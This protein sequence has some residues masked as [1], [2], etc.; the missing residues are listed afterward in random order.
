MQWSLIMR[1]KHEQYT[2]CVFLSL[3]KSFRKKKL[4]VPLCV[5]V[6]VG[7][8][9]C[10][11]VCVCV[12]SPWLC[13]RTTHLLFCC[14]NILFYSPKIVTATVLFKSPKMS[15]IRLLCDVQNGKEF[16]TVSGFTAWI[17]LVLERYSTWNAIGVSLIKVTAHVFIIGW[18]L[19]HLSVWFLLMF[20]PCFFVCALFATHPAYEG[21][22]QMN[23]SV[24]LLHEWLL[25]VHMPAG[26]PWAWVTSSQK[27]ASLMLLQFWSVWKAAFKA[28]AAKQSIIVFWFGT[29][30]FSGFGGLGCPKAVDI[31]RLI[32]H[33]TQL[34]TIRH[35]KERG[36]V[37]RTTNQGVYPI[38]TLEPP[39]D[40]HSTQFDLPR[41]RRSP[42][43]SFTGKMKAKCCCTKE[44]EFQTHSMQ[45][46]HHK[47][48]NY[49][50]FA[51]TDGINWNT[52]FKKRSSVSNLILA[53]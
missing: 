52:S 50:T 11:C 35:N 46:I 33:V 34:N 24:V 31:P 38:H 22:F 41:R 28:F 32:T 7:M 25:G 18:M 2:V 9:V 17:S 36:F 49:I 42:Y 13:N 20:V 10:V 27:T 5:C 12:C 39:E 3:F 29:L 26:W 23:G 1:L 8:C 43:E 40:R 16:H 6:C 51:E 30:H 19:E 15:F 48:L 37:F 4:N 44:Q 47:W 53:A 45:W 21:F 14:Q